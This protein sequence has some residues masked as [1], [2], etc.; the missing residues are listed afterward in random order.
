MSGSGDTEADREVMG[1][2]VARL[3]AA[4]AEAAGTAAAGD[5]Q[6]VVA[7]TCSMRKI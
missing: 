1:S 4:F 2:L 7:I 3:C 5:N 6:T